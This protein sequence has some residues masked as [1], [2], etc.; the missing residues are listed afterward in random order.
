M[1]PV[2]IDKVIAVQ[3]K[4]RRRRA[5]LAAVVC[6]LIAAVTFVVYAGQG[7][8]A[9]GGVTLLPLDDAY[10]HLR[11]ADQ[12]AH[13]Q[14]YRYNSDDPPTS[15]ATSFLYP[16]LLAIGVRLPADPLDAALWSM[17]IGAVAFA[18]SG[19]LIYLIAE[20]LKAGTLL[21]ALAML[22]FMLEGANAWHAMS[23]METSLVVFASLLTLY[24]VIGDRLRLGAAAGALSALLRPEGALIAG[25]AV[26]ALGVKQIQNVPNRRLWLVPPRWAWRR[27]W[28]WL[29]LPIVAVGVQPLANLLVTGSVVATGN[30][31]KSLFG[32]VP[33]N[34]DEI[35]RRIV[36]N[37]LRIWREFLI[38]DNLLVVGLLLVVVAAALWR[39]DRTFTLMLA[40]WAILFALAISTLDTA[41]WHFKRYQMPLLALRPVLAVVA[42]A[43][44]MATLR[45]LRLN[46]A[47]A[48]GR[49][50][51]L[52]WLGLVVA[53]GLIVLSTLGAASIGLSAASALSDYMLNVNLVRQQPYTLAQVL[54]QYPDREARVAVHDV[55]LMRYLGGLDTVDIV[56]LTTPGAAD[57]WRNGPGSVG[58]FIERQ[59]PDLIANYGVGHGL[60]LGYLAETDLYAETLAEFAVAMTDDERPR[61]VA[62][63]ADVQ[64][65]YRPDWT[66]AERAESSPL[67][68]LTPYLRGLELV[69][70]LDV[71]DIV[72][73]RDHAYRWTAVQPLGG[74]PTEYRQY[75]Q[76]GCIAGSGGCV[77]MDG[78]RRINGEESF[79]LNTRPGL[80][81]VLIARIHAADPGALDVYAA[82]ELVAQRI[83]PALPGNWLD[84]PIFIPGELVSEATTIRLV[85][86]VSADYQ[87]YFY[88]AYQGEYT[89]RELSS[90][91]AS[92]QHD[93]IRLGEAAITVETYD[94]GRR[95]LVVRL[96]WWTD[97]RA[98]GDLKRYLH[99]LDSDGVVAAQSDGY[100]ARGSLPPG[101]WLAGMFIETVEIDVTASPAGVY[102]LVT[103]LYDAVS[104]ERPTA[105]GETVDEFG[106]IGIG[107]VTLGP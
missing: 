49:R 52:P 70:Q 64:G 92:L 23:G 51:V 18:A 32:M 71:A 65:I 35:I 39:R 36:D 68:G 26:F 50:D 77:S 67:S 48:T 30:S 59:R 73:E 63:A 102:T 93:A 28:L 95:L 34:T 10:I 54:R 85:P 20:L 91:I 47:G 80:D 96:P 61:N 19:L 90:T 60:G 16:Y 45:M 72:S 22:A 38:F 25:L 84:V 46:A 8:S 101:N 33:P 55:G 87:P 82:G 11:Y 44:L 79:V 43:W 88:R 74:F 103:G 9:A 69:D 42:A 97:G 7:R 107:E 94:D 56:G 37:F 3:D 83:I 17:A 105:T 13:G 104:G 86:R 27:Q 100:P 40:I 89:A 41:F 75:D 1:T 15:G 106:R 12:I 31:A 6:V 78:G 53:V 29:L 2:D 24:A 14:F 99:I 98:T 5:A 62:L 58:E 81:L 4:A 76:I 57:Y 21:S 66:A